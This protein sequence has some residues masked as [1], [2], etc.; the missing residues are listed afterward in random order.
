MALP[1]QLVTELE[2]GDAAAVTINALAERRFAARVTEIGVAATGGGSTFPV[3]VRLEDADPAVLSGMAAEVA[4]T[5]GADDLERIFLVPASAIG[6]DHHGR[7]AFVVRDLQDGQG[8]ARRVA[9]TTGDLTNAGLEVLDGLAEGD[10]L[11]TAG[12]HRIN[13]GQTVLVPQS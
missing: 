12:V 10:L 13:D 7:Y 3:T 9:V 11:I 2:V 4:L 6:E 1:G 5:F 8:T